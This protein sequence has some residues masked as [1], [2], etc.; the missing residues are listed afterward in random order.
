MIYIDIPNGIFW[1][2]DSYGDNDGIPIHTNHPEQG[3]SCRTMGE[4]KLG[5]LGAW[6]FGVWKAESTWPIPSLRWPQPSVGSVI[7]HL[8]WFSG[9]LTMT[10]DLDLVGTQSNQI[11]STY[12]EI[13]GCPWSFLVNSNDSKAW[14][15]S[16]RTPNVAPDSTANHSLVSVPFAFFAFL[17]PKQLQ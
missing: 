16:F 3:L 8:P 12:V 13:H 5:P 11:V 14:G 4:P 17:G 2:W 10:V 9:W 15:T 7:T 1:E 6:L